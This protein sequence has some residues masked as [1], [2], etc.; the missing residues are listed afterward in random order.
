LPFDSNLLD[1]SVLA[2][3]PEA[4]HPDCCWPLLDFPLDFLLF[5]LLVLLFKLLLF[6]D[7]FVSRLLRM[8]SV[9]LTGFLSLS[10]PVSG[11]HILSLYSYEVEG[12][13]FAVSTLR[14][15]VLEAVWESLVEPVT[16][17]SIILVAAGS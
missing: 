10:F 2:A 9:G 7:L 13:G 4:C 16:K 8:S 6:E 15:F 3:D 11:I 12:S 5:E 17:G 1:K 14:Y